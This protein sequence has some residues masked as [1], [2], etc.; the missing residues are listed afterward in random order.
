MLARPLACAALLAAALPSTSLAGDVPEGP[1]LFGHPVHVPPP[2]TKERAEQLRASFLQ[3][4]EDNDLV[5]TG[6]RIMPRS[7]L[8]GAHPQHGVRIDEPHYATIFLNFFG[9][10]LTSG[11]NAAEMESNCAGA[12]GIDYPGYVGSQADALAIIQVFENA[13]EPYAVR[14]AYE[15]P[16]PQHLP[17]SMV[18][19]GG[20]PEDAGQ[21]SGTLGVSCSTDCGDVWWRDTTL[22]FT[23]QSGNPVTLGNTALQEAAHAFGLDHIDG[24]ENIMYPFSTFGTKVWATECTPYNAATGPIG[25]GYIHEV[26]C[27][28]GEAQNDDAELLAYFGPNA[29]DVEAPLVTIVEPAPDTAVASGGSTSIVAEVTDDHLGHGW[30]LRVVPP[31]GD[32]VILNAYQFETSWD[33]NFAGQPDGAYELWIEAVDHDGNE[34]S[35]MVTLYVGTEPPIPGTDESGD[36]SGSAG[37]EDGTGAGSDDSAPT[38]DDGD[39]TGATAPIDEGGGDEGCACRAERGERWSWALLPLVVVGL[40]SRRRARH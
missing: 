18:M 14:V 31:A 1:T 19:M 20:S 11:T 37:S 15:D 38:D 32:E 22:A 33:L 27:P 12:A 35:A 13:M 6:D 16:P 24:Q 5:S 29:P 34:G 4:L 39:G 26:F 23:E 7:L 10:P 17:Y 40:A 36:G 30:R 21:E 3:H 8:G 28:D 9:G 2:L 25:C